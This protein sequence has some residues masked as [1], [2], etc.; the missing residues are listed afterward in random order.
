MGSQSHLPGGSDLVLFVDLP[1]PPSV[2][3]IWH[4]KGRKMYRSKSYTLWL[5]AADAAATEQ[6]KLI[7]VPWKGGPV[8]IVMT[9]FRGRGWRKGRDLDNCAKVL[10]DWLRTRGHLVEDSWEYVSSV[11]VRIDY[12][13]PASI[14]F[15]EVVAR[16]DGHQWGGK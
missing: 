12:G 13:E 2:N 15:V 14:A 10:I 8:Q 5:K 3:S 1:I 16:A 7:G 9:V 11:T 4:K 6:G